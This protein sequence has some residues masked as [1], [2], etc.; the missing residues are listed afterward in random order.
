MFDA[1]KQLTPRDTIASQSVGQ[2]HLRHILQ[3]LQQSLEEPLCSV[4][5]APGL[6]NGTSTTPF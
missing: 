4:G 2:D 1:G 5:I 3:T 6:D